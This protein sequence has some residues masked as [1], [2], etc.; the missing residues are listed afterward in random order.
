[1]IKRVHA[2][3]IP[4]DAHAFYT[5]KVISRDGRPTLIDFSISS[6]QDDGTNFSNLRLA[7][8][9]IGC[10]DANVC[11]LKQTHSSKV[12]FVSSSLIIIA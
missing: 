4:E 8:Q 10:S 11:Y 5:N 12:L 3:L 7:A 1:M 9:N 6:N 2:T